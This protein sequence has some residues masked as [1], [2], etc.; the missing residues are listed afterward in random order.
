MPVDVVVVDK[1]GQPIRGLRAADFQL[2][3]RRQ[4]Q[5]ILA[6]EEVSAPVSVDAAMPPLLAAI[7]K[8]VADNRWR[9]RSG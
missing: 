7:K 8:D 3:D 5:A 2:F 1:N 9:N 4:R 6:F